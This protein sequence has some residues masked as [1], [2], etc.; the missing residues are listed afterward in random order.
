MVG[1]GLGVPVGAEVVA[2]AMTRATVGVTTVQLTVGAAVGVAIIAVTVEAAF[3]ATI[4]VETGRGPRVLV[5]TCTES[6]AAGAAEE[7]QEAKETG[8]QVVGGGASKAR[9][10][11][12]AG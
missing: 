8:P 2:G 11:R 7:G 10:C 3:G 1:V 5:G 6:G 4:N 12:T 9:A